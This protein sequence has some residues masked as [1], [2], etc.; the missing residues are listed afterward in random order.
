MEPSLPLPVVG[1]QMQAEAFRGMLR[2][3]S[4][5]V[6]LSGRIRFRIRPQADVSR[7]PSSASNLQA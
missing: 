4:R 5:F 3:K 2:T 7:R 6:Q 1:D